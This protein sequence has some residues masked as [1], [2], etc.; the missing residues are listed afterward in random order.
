MSAFVCVAV[1]SAVSYGQERG[2]QTATEGRIIFTHVRLILLFIVMASTHVLYNNVLQFTARD[3][4]VN[5][6]VFTHIE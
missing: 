5:G 3:K 6:W 4:L 1:G 2:R